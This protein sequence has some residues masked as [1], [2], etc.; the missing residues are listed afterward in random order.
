[1]DA[2]GRRYSVT[3]I[4]S[5]QQAAAPASMQAGAP[6]SRRTSFN[7]PAGGGLAD[8]GEDVI[9]QAAAAGGAQHCTQTH[10][11]TAWALTTHATAS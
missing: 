11:C 4:S 2:S 10:A 6:L 3:A 8:L 7:V 5:P 1:M 9:A